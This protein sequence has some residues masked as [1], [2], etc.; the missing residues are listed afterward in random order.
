MK[1]RIFILLGLITIIFS[2][3][4]ISSSNNNTPEILF[5]SKPFVI[6]SDTLNRYYT[7]ESGVYL[8][9]TIHVGD[10]I[11]FR[12]L[13]NGFSNNL[14]T[15]KILQSDTSSTKIIFPSSYSLDSIFSAA[16]SD[17]SNGNFLFK[18]KITSLY[19][20]F[21]YI[22]KK[23]NN[24]AKVTFYISSDANFSDMS[25]MG[26]NSVSFVLKTPIKI[27]KPKPVL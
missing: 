6:N 8:L 11:I 1:T 18:N 24:D 14:S 7:G 12:M 4:N 16:S 2:S 27:P 17:F 19:F 5:V 10:T 13:F 23:A 9:D 21:K 15:L 22:A 20:P 26:N 25:S 3:C